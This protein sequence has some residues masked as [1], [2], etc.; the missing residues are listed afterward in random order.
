[1]VESR[2]NKTR[3]PS[4]DRLMAQHF[5][6]LYLK[7]LFKPIHSTL[8]SHLPCHFPVRQHRAHLDDPNASS[9]STLLLHPP[10]CLLA[11]ASWQSVQCHLFREDCWT[12]LLCVLKISVSQYPFVTEFHDNFVYSPLLPSPWSVS[13]TPMYAPWA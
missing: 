10:K 6:Q 11:F 3:S 12:S 2:I 1:M 4:M 8:Q 9:W 7:M 13:P 5:K